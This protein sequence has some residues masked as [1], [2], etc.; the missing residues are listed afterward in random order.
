MQI[1]SLKQLVEPASVDWQGIKLAS[2]DFFDT[3]VWRK[4]PEIN[5]L[6]NCL[7]DFAKRHQLTVNIDDFMHWREQI[8]AEVGAQNQTAESDRE[9]SIYPWYAGVF[10]NFSENSDLADAFCQ[11]LLA[12]EAANLYLRSDVKQTF[13]ALQRRG[14]RCVI[15]SDTYYPAAFFHDFLHD[16][17]LSGLVDALFLSCDLGVNKA[18]GKLFYNLFARQSVRP[19]QVI[20][21]GDN[22][23]SDVQQARRAGISAV[24]FVEPDNSEQQ[25]Q[26]LHDF[27]KQIIAP[28]LVVFSDWLADNTD[29]RR[30]LLFLARDGFLLHRAFQSR[31]PQ[32]KSDYVY[33]NRVIANQLSFSALDATTLAMLNRQHKAEGAWGLVKVFGLYQTAFAEQ[34]QLFIDRQQLSQ[35][36]LLNDTLCAQLLCEQPLVEQ[37]AAALADKQHINRQ[38][39]QQYLRNEEVT[40]VDVGWRGSIFKQLAPLFAAIRDCRLLA[41]IQA[42]EQGIQ[43][44]VNPQRQSDYLVSL[45]EYRDLLEWALSEDKGA[46]VGIDQQLSPVFASNRVDSAKQRVQQGVSE[47]L[48]AIGKNKLSGCF[49]QVLADWQGYFAG[50]PTAF[51]N[52]LAKIQSEMGIDGQSGVR[53]ADFLHKGSL[54]SSQS[55]QQSIQSQS[56]ISG[57]LALVAELKQAPQLVVYGAGSGFEFV[58]P[59]LAGSIDFI[60]DINRSLQ[61]KH[62]QSLLVKSPDALQQ[63]TGT[64]LVSVIGRKQQ[65]SPLLQ[66]TNCKTLFLEDYV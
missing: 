18:S 63:V 53:F 55:Q 29:P 50:L 12:A 19:E 13:Q 16:N 37:F 3:L 1:T 17:G 2:F 54:A 64:L 11:Q 59:H 65:I 51:I 25:Q 24:Q 47:G 32:R 48:Q 62:V 14:I 36:S 45:S 61:G 26:A 21:I 58:Y 42:D 10:A 30:T 43:S 22:L 41:S 23:H 15:T 40:L 52:A 5:L 34:L 31:Y 27:G 4:Q 44:A 8:Y 60:V 6:Q 28:L 56:R 35:D 46:C 33:L 20:H 38:Y 39:L 49:Q 9:L 66:H 7:R 57:F